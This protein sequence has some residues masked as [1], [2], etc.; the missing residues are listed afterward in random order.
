[1]LDPHH[2][3]GDLENV[4]G[5][6]VLWRRQAFTIHDHVWRMDAHRFVCVKLALCLIPVQFP[7]KKGI[8]LD[9]VYA[10]AVADENGIPGLVVNGKKGVQPAFYLQSGVKKIYMLCFGKFHP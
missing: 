2:A 7:A 10:Y 6:E 5:F 1:M 3:V 8:T 9:V 4:K